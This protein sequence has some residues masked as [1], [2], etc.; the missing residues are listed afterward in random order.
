MLNPFY[1]FQVFSMVLWFWDGYIVYS[2]CIFVI[3]MM[4]ITQNLYDITHNLA[5]VR[6][7]ARFECPLVVNR[8]EDESN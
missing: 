1:I 3:S 6:K 7:I 8:R 5:S 2:I 4:G